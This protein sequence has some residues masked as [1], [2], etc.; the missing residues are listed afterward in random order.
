MKDSIFFS[1]CWQRNILRLSGMK[2]SAFIYLCIATSSMPVKLCCGWI[3]Y[4]PFQI[5]L[6]ASQAE[7]KSSRSA[8]GHRSVCVSMQAPLCPPPPLL[9]QC[10][11]LWFAL[12]S[13]WA[14]VPFRCEL[15]HVPLT[16]LSSYFNTPTGLGAKNSFKPGY[17]TVFF[18]FK[19]KREEIKSPRSSPPLPCRWLWLLIKWASSVCAVWCFHL[20][21]YAYRQPVGRQRMTWDESHGRCSDLMTVAMVVGW[22]FK[23]D[24]K[25]RRKKKKKIY[26]S[27]SRVFS[28]LCT[29]T[30]MLTHSTSLSPYQ[31]ALQSSRSSFGSASCKGPSLGQQGGVQHPDS[32]SRKEACMANC[33]MRPPLKR[34]K[35]TQLHSSLQRGTWRI[36]SRSS[37]SPRWLN[38]RFNK[39]GF[40]L[41]RTCL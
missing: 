21:I 2:R 15:I 22:E 32:L 17:L 36:H 18:F 31:P 35:T 40:W 12:I 24:I 9:P 27:L 34:R 29:Y 1:F 39:N 14:I 23:S 37:A 16:T 4:H 26:F 10:R 6:T 3:F 13:L 11:T 33:V 19:K 30:H 28:H 38:E 20:S 5:P 8:C 25:G 41:Q 7:Q